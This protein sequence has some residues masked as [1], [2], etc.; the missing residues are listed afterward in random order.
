MEEDEED[1]LLVC[2]SSSHN[3]TYLYIVLNFK[4]IHI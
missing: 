1:E 3:S 4:Y 2:Y